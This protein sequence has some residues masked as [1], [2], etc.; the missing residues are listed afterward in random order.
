ML[1]V[2]SATLTLV[3]LLSNLSSLELNIHKKIL[4]P[5]KPI[6]IIKKLYYN[7]KRI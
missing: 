6:I 7:N 3:K 2:T 4:N 5:T 1:W